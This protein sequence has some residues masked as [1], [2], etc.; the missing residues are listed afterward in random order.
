MSVNVNEQSFVTLTLAAYGWSPA[1]WAQVFYP[2]DLPSEWQPAFYAN[3]FIRILLPAEGWNA[4]ALAQTATWA[5]ETDGNV[6][7][8][9][10]L[11]RELLQAAHW[12]QVQTTVEQILAANVLGL[13]VDSEAMPLL[14]AGWVE[15][16]AVHQRVA[17][18]WLAVM[19]AGAEAQVGLLPSTQAFTP[20]ALREIFE[21]LQQRTAHR[22]VILFLDTPYA[23][24]EQMRLM[25]QLYGIA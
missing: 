13:L 3:E 11:T 12:Q 5:S 8:Y 18:E 16:F 17:G 19:P 7:F 1:N 4:A 6:G 22:D 14:P 10:A 21:Q 20:V 9:L 25:Q 23:V 2:D 15:R 24:V